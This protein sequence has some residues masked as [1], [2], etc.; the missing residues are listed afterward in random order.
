MKTSLFAD[1]A[2]MGMVE[3][4]VEAMAEEGLEFPD[5]KGRTETRWSATKTVDGL[6]RFDVSTTARSGEGK[7]VY[8]VAVCV[9][10][11]A[12]LS[13]KGGLIKLE[14]E[15]DDFQEGDITCY[16]S[17]RREQPGAP[18][19]GTI[20]GELQ[21]GCELGNLIDFE[22]HE[23][24]YSGAMMLLRLLVIKALRIAKRKRKG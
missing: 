3:H 17:R 21:A 8:T 22:H 6:F 7:V 5:L 14:F 10:E 20:F 13:S 16:E 15:S 12:D 1:T 9:R 19:C 4:L 2:W 24:D 11:A 23:T 18:G